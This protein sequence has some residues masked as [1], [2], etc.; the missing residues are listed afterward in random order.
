M[1]H[2][3]P[4]MI[5]KHR[6]SRLVWKIILFGFVPVGI[7]SHLAYHMITG[8]YLITS[9]IFDIL[10]LAFFLYFLMGLLK[11]FFRFRYLMRNVRLAVT[12]VALM[13]I[14]AE[15]VFILTAYKSTQAEKRS[16]YYYESPYK[17][18]RKSWFH[19]WQ[20][21]HDL[22]SDEYCYHRTIN[23]LGL[24]DMEHPV[25]KNDHEFRIIGLG[26][27]YT[28]GDGTDK[29]ST[30]LKFLERSLAKYPVNRPV[31]YINAGA[32]GSDPFFEYILLKEKLLKYKPDLVILTLNA[33]DIS[34]V[35]IRGG[36]ERFQPDGSLKYN[37]P[38][39]FEPVYATSHL[40]R[41]IFDNVLK[42]DEL[43]IKRSKNRYVPEEM[44]RKIYDC[45]LLFKELSIE[46]HFR[47]LI[48]FHPLNYEVLC[49]RLDLA[50]VM[51]GISADSTIGL[52][53]MLWYFRTKE[54]IGQTNFS[55]YFWKFNGHHNAKGYAAFARGIEW[56]LDELGIVDSLM[57]K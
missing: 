21:D 32:C 11:K 37:K 26:D 47:L 9:G 46:Y 31:T 5:R 53:D 3:E 23:S 49:N 22:R 41:L 15:A 30:W 48:V 33:T 39:W 44:V 13:L 4:S 51:A 54:S 34:D 40:S 45:L 8:R 1:R 18:E 20:Q 35:T 19:V 42:Y 10:F 6:S 50:P 43:L 14:L 24:S 56:K 17:P 7:I 55:S 12:S 36:I 57:Q 25:E 52:L 27:S 29:D 28:E 38:P 16:G 2:K